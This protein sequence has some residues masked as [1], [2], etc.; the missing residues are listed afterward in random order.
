MPPIELPNIFLASH[1][2]IMYL[3]TVEIHY[4]YNDKIVQLVCIHDALSYL[5]YTFDK[6]EDIL[7]YTISC[8]TNTLLTKEFFSF[9][10][11]KLVTEF[12]FEDPY[13]V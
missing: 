1:N 4:Q 2:N 5:I 11:D 10:C 6:T 8:G 9:R 12:H 13:L 7:E 3:Y